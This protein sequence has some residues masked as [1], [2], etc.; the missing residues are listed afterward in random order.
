MYI[1]LFH[2]SK[3]PLRYPHIFSLWPFQVRHNRVNHMGYLIYLCDNHYSGQNLLFLNYVL[4]RIKD[5]LVL[6]PYDIFFAYE[7]IRDHLL[8]VDIFDMLL[9]HIIFFLK[10]YNQIIHLHYNIHLLY[11]LLN[12]FLLLHIV[13]LYFGDVIFFEYLFLF[14]YEFYHF[15]L[16]FGLL[17]LFL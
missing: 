4:N 5:S 13:V 3:Y 16:L 2:Y 17:T 10:L 6:N 8:I 9:L 14:L 12:Q 1:I 7:D 15:F 11:I